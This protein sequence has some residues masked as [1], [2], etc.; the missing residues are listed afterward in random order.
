M[1]RGSVILVSVTK[2]SA[3]QGFIVVFFFHFLSSFP[4]SV[5]IK[6]LTLLSSKRWFV[7]TR[8]EGLRNTSDFKKET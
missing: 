7:S 8:H 4:T 6:L 1:P 2:E 3:V 5:K